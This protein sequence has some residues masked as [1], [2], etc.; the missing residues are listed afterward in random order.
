[1]GIK[2]A[3][4]CE[5]TYQLINIL[6]F[7]YGNTENSYRNS[8]I[9]LVNKFRNYD[10]I[11]EK[12]EQE[13][14]FC[15]VYKVNPYNYATNSIVAK[16][17]VLEALLN[18]KKSIVTQVENKGF[19]LKKYQKIVIA[20][21]THIAENFIFAERQKRIYLIEDGVGTYLQK[22]INILKSRYHNVIARVLYGEYEIEKI[23]LN[24]PEM[25]QG[26]WECQINK[27]IVNNEKKDGFYLMLERILKKNRELRNQ[28]QIIFLS[29]IGINEKQLMNEK[30]IVDTIKE[31]LKDDFTIRLHPDD[32]IDKYDN[33][34]LDC[35]DDI[36]ELVSKEKIFDT[37]ILISSF[38]T[39]QFVPKL[40]YNKEPI[41]IFTGYLFTDDKKEHKEMVSL[42]SYLYKVYNK[43]DKII[44]V[45]SYKELKEI[46]GNIYREV[47]EEE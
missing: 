11:V 18:P 19:Q 14:V 27:L 42:C 9:Y 47:L 17:Q 38:S 35:G 25:Y 3:F 15:N 37:S 39:A 41:L 46:L 44:I 16:L 8:D 33:I 45:T 34:F 36:W 4:W 21:Q 43:K 29:Q 23:Y 24:E 12:L 5:T 40:L 30:K 32:P 7:V 6:K 26:E 10:Y 1:M 13:K 2:F 22:K 31:V 20:S 28:N